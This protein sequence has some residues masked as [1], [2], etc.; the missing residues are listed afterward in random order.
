[1]Q[2]S[3]RARWTIYL[4]NNPHNS[5]NVLSL[6]DIPDGRIPIEIDPYDPDP[7]LDPVWSVNDGINTLGTPLGSPEFVKQYL[8]TKLEKH[9]TI[10]TFITDVAKT[11]FSKESHKMLT[12]SAIPRLSHILKFVPKNETSKEWMEEA[13]KEHMSTWL[14]CDG[15]STLESAVTNEE[16]ALLSASLDLPPQF[17][18]A[19]LQS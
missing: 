17:G 16:R 10:L 15:T 2:Q 6:H 18:G 11:G 5:E 12:L 13:N 9:K 14:T 4:N 19:G 7:C 3:A 8:M 1:M